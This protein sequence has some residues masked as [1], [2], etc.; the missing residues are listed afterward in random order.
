MGQPS[1]FFVFLLLAAE[2][3]TVN[4]L[5]LGRIG[6][7]SADIDALEGAV[8]LIHAVV[9]TLRN[10]AVDAGILL[11][12]HLLRLLSVDSKV[13]CAAKQKLT[14]PKNIFTR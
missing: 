11:I 14:H 6:L 12:G 5:S 8:V 4:T 10:S 3:V 9:C 2:R 1:R 7:M 13:V